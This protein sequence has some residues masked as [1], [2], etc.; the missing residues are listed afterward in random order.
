MSQLRVVNKSS[1]HAESVMHLKM[2]WCM[3]EWADR[4]MGEQMDG[5]TNL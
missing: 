2:D 5:Q 1:V 4:Q 3:G